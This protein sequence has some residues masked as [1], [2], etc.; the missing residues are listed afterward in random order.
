M[1]SV[2]I[3]RREARTFTLSARWRNVL[4]RVGMGIF[5][6][7]LWEGLVTWLA[8]SYITRPSGIAKSAWEVLSNRPTPLTVLS[9]SFWYDVETTMIAVLEGLAIGVVLGVFVGLAMGR[10]RDVDSALKY[11]LGALF[12]M[13]TIAMIPLMELWWGF[14][15][16]TRLA[17]VILGAFLPVALQVY[18]GVKKLPPTYIEVARTYH[19]R[20]WNVWFGIALPASLPYLLAGLRL[21]VG[22]ALVGAVVAEYLLAIKGLGYYI[23]ADTQ[24]FHENQAMWGVIML[25]VVGVLMNGA[26]DLA[27]KK[28]LPW[29]RREGQS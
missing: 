25:A 11:Y 21:S 3:P 27:T 6:L 19:A 18:D 14:T 5:L 22:R 4:L 12:A 16:T 24:S 20:W 29:Y 1:T 26:I 2:A 15:G 9:G 13:P 7:L 10:L 28:V 23:R 17:I 8:P